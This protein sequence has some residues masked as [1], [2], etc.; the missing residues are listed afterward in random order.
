MSIISNRHNINLFEAGKSAP[1]AGQR[2][3]KV[4]Y[5][6]TQKAPAK[7]PSV[8]VSL[9]QIEIND[10]TYVCHQV[11]F[12]C[13]V[14]AALETAQDG[15]VRALYESSVGTLKSVGDSELSVT[16]CLAFIESQNGSGRLTTESVNAWFD[17]TLKET[18]VVVIADK[19]G[20]DELN[21]EQMAVIEKH[22]NGCKGLFASLSSGATI[23]TPAQI[24]WCRNVLGKVEEDGM[25]A[26]LIARLD[27]MGNKKP[28]EELLEL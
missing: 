19:L 8:C 11:E 23:I 16:A 22:L 5:K 21:E 28:V 20:F 13:I 15:I 14:K 9:P 25:S 18:L 4:G 24:K 1:L 2:L 3:A 26:R 10:D 6:S 7:F 17:S 12:T 27:S